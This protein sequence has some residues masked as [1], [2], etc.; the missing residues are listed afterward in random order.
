[1]GKAFHQNI[2]DQGIRPLRLVSPKL[3]LV[4]AATVS[5]DTVAVFFVSAP[6]YGHTFPFFMVKRLHFF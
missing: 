6:K 3:G 4:L 5:V 1:M 2:P